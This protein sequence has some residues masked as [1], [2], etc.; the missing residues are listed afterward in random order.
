MLDKGTLDALLPPE[1]SEEQKHAVKSM[2]E[3]VQRVLQPSKFFVYFYLILKKLENILKSQANSRK[4][5]MK[6]VLN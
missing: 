5:E 1:A 3:H 4:N 2:F 6:E